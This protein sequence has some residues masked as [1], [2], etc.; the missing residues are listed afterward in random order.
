[1]EDVDQVTL[2]GVCLQVS[3]KHTLLALFSRKTLYFHSHI[4]LDGNPV[5]ILSCPNVDNIQ[6]SF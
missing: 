6:T 1:M 3:A 2:E 5:L 4:F